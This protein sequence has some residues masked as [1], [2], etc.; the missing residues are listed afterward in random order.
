MN[1]EP[2][3]PHYHQFSHS[4]LS[5]AILTVAIYLGQDILVPLAM[6]GL[7]AVLLRPV[8]ERLIR[9]GLHKVFAIS[10]ALLLAIVVVAGLGVILSM[11][12]ADFSDDLPKLRQ[13]IN[14]LVDDAR[15]WV[16]REYNVSYRQQEKYLQKA[17]TQTLDS[18]QSAS[19]LGVITGPLGTLTLVPIYVFL[20]LYYRSMLLHFVVVLFSEKHT[21]RVREVL[22]EVKI[23]IQS[24]VVGL[25]IETACVAAL[26]SA[27]LLILGVQ[28][29]VLLGII[30]AI[31]NL[32][33]YIGGLVATVLTVLVTFGNQPDM[34][35]M[36]GVL[37]VFLFVQFIDN[38]LLVPLIVGSKVRVNALVS[39]VGVLVGGA[40]AGVSGMFL[41]IPAI[42]IMKVIFDRVDSLRPWGVLLGDQTPEQAGSNLFRLKRRRKAKV[43]ES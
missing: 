18:L 32:I 39:I 12:L 5:L 24:Y 19:T 14:D 33:P 1:P 42:A 35:I 28:Y 37:G 22:G 6:A 43:I 4:L 9:L 21:E 34:S 23:V 31:L 38:N 25:L 11:Q 40:L 20:L 30:A 15:Q 10:I 27:G 36:F 29:A 2:T 8:E 16:R 17:Q 26:N 41:S 7:I 13:N 3:R